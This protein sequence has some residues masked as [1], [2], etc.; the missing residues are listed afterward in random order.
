M[1]INE[2]DI[3]IALFSS[4][5]LC[6]WI[7]PRVLSCL[8][9]PLCQ[10]CLTRQ[11]CV[12]FIF[13]QQNTLRIQPWSLQRT[14]IL[15][16]LMWLL[17]CEFLLA[18]CLSLS[19]DIFNMTYRALFMSSL[20]ILVHLEIPHDTETRYSWNAVSSVLWTWFSWE[21]MGGYVEHIVS[22]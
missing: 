14:H 12:F 22:Y 13:F 15:H 5:K 9:S 8:D 6:K 2:L 18:H 11:G 10:Q 19:E 7:W 20:P 17:F 4:N 1:N 21:W 3:D 16:L